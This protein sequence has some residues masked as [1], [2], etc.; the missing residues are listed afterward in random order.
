[1]RILITGARGQVGSA[2]ARLLADTGHHEVL[3]VDRHQCDLVSRDSV[4][5]VVGTFAPDLIINGAAH[6]NV[7]GCESDQDAAFAVNGLGVRYL[8]AAANRVDA[9]IVHISTDYVFDGRSAV[10]YDEW[11]P[12][13]PQSVYGT[14]KLAGEVELM[15]HANRWTIARTAWVYG[16]GKNF[17]DTI[18]S[19]ARDGQ[20]LTVVDDQRGCPT[21]AADL[22]AMLITLG[23]GRR[24]GMFHVTNQGSCSWFDLARVALALVDLEPDIVSPMSSS[25]LN[26]PAPRPANSVLDNRALRLGGVPLLRPFHDALADYLD[27]APLSPDRLAALGVA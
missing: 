8:A 7:D 20:S 1:V 4:E 9:H 2:A 27:V 5:Q 18:I 6:T 3:A 21:F 23:T 15:A 16:N 13:N 26:R 22:A 11:H 14:S 10:P 17:V 12:T 24:S 25:E 19:K